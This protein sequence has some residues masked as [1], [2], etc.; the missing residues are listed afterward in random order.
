MLSRN[1]GPGGRRNRFAMLATTTLQLPAGKYRLA[2]TADDGVRVDMDGRRVIDSWA[3]REVAEDVAPLELDGAS[4]VFHVE[5]FQANGE[6]KLWL[7]LEP[8]GTEALAA[9]NG[10]VSHPTFERRLQSLSKA[11]EQ[12][13]ASASALSNRGMWFMRYGH[14]AEAASDLGA[15]MRQDSTNFHNGWAASYAYFQAGDR[16]G[17]ERCC[18]EL[19]DRWEGTLD[20]RT[21]E[22]LAR[23][24]ALWPG[25]IDSAR[26]KRVADVPVGPETTVDFQSWINLAKGVVHCR[27][28]EMEQAADDLYQSLA[29]DNGPCAQAAALYFLAIAHQHLG[30]T[31]QARGFMDRA[32]ALESEIAPE[33][34]L[35]DMGFNNWLEWILAR[36]GRK[37]AEAILNHTTTAR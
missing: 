10:M 9:A 11:V 2:V 8:V 37:E 35:G 7:R 33:A 27:A 29:Y 21:Q 16:E 17:Y 22:R 24:C 6:I 18:K 3:A 20:E 30:Q 15:A 12:N 5:Y 36:E 32:R 25:V 19:L 14:F 26:L 31:D 23:A 28:G 34:G 13:P 1:F 4:H